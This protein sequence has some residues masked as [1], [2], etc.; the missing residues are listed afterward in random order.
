MSRLRDKYPIL[1]WFSKPPT[2]CIGVT[3]GRLADDLGGF[4]AAC[5]YSVLEEWDAEGP[6]GEVYADLERRTV[7]RDGTVAKA[8]LTV[9]GHAVLVDPELLLTTLEDEITDFCSRHE[10]TFTAAM[11]ERRS[12]TVFFGRYDAGGTKSK[13]W[14]CQGRPVEEQVDPVRT[15]T[16]KPGHRQLVRAMRETGVSTDDLFGT[17][18]ARALLLR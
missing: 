17:V 13:T 16:K 15:I 1:G 6:F 7:A 11:W 3:E 4:P 8:V 2:F 5:G 9:P 10:T 14:Y 18:R 12:D